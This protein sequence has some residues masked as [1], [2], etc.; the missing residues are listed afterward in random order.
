MAL[1]EAVYATGFVSALEP[2]EGRR[3]PRLGALR[4][5]DEMYATSR[6]PL[7]VDAVHEATSHLA[8]TAIVDEQEDYQARE[9]DVEDHMSH[10]EHM[11]DDTINF[12]K[13]MKE[14]MELRDRIT[15][16]GE[17]EHEELSKVSV[18]VSTSPLGDCFEST[19]R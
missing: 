12:L 11:D 5:L 8:A 7:N 15:W 1:Y 3:L 6:G 9:S 13:P 19:R 10:T 16:I 17:T 2:I 18:T 4:D 14:R